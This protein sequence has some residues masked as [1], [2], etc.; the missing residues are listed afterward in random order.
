MSC[1][2]CCFF[3]Q[4]AENPTALCENEPTLNGQL[5]HSPYYYF[6]LGLLCGAVGFHIGWSGGTR[7][8]LPLARAG[9]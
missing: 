7:W 9:E 1:R 2:G 4:P 6:V 3:A 5:L 8:A